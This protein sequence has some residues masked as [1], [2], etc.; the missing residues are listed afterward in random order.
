MIFNS[1][2]LDPDPCC[3]RQVSDL[4][5]TDF[6]YFD[7]D[8]FELNVAE[9]KFYRAMGYP[10]EY[11]ILNHCCWQEPWVVKTESTQLI[12]DHSM[13]LHRASYAGEAYEQLSMLHYYPYSW[14]LVAAKQ[15]WGLDFALDCVSTSGEVFEVLH[16]EYDSYNF[17]RFVESKDQLEAFITSTDWAHIAEKI[18]NLRNEW[19]HLPGS[20]QNH[21]KSNYILGW[22]RAEYTEKAM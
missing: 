16:I 14:L 18:W 8:G 12:I 19:Q 1:I 5:E 4:E 11:P 7:K 6:L 10:V 15:K 2:E 3:T 20:E 21:W 22:E 13:I 9:Q 17:G